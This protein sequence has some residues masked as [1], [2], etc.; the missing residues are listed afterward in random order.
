[1]YD[2]LACGRPVVTAD[3]P[4][5]RELLRDGETALLVPAGDGAALAA[6]LRRLQ[7]GAERARLGAAALAL[8]HRALTPPAVA[9][10]LLEALEA[11]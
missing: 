8:Y 5:A 1:V 11:S 2:G 3:T 6:A 9:G 10:K 4:G 7:P